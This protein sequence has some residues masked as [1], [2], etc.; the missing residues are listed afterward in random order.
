MAGAWARMGGY[1]GLPVAQPF[2]QH[3][4]TASRP[5]TDSFGNRAVVAQPEHRSEP[6]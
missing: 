3:R 5:Q 2:R 6:P 1:G 4:H